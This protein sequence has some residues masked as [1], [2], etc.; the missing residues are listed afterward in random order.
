VLKHQRTL[1][2]YAN[3]GFYLRSAKHGIR[4]TTRMRAAQRR[5]AAAT[6]SEQ[7][8][9]RAVARRHARRLARR[10]ATAPPRVAICHVFG[11]RY[12]RQALAV[13]WCESRHSTR[14][15]NGQYRG[16]FQMGSYER[17]QFG[18]GRTAHAQAKAAHRYFAL[19]G[20]DWSPW[21]CKP[22]Y[23]M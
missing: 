2:F 3:H 16:L 6:R 17:Q 4:A 9:R 13:A 22:W 21:S 11:R 12:C 5:L 19:T 8:L 15:E 10:L 20:R 18:H 14:A 1:R 7:Q 23:A